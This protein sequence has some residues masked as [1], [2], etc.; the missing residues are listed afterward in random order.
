MIVGIAVATIVLS[1]AARNMP[2]IAAAVVRMMRRFE[3]RA[4][5]A[6]VVLIGA[7]TGGRRAGAARDR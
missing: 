1:S 5:Y 2:A 4:A 3:S 7:L 6:V